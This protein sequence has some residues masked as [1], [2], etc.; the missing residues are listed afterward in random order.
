MPLPVGDDAVARDGWG[1]KATAHTPGEHHGEVYKRH[2]QCVCVYAKET[3]YRAI[4]A[5][6]NRVRKVQATETGCESATDTP[7]TCEQNRW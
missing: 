2:E 5:H 7:P 4:L 3:A 6:A 1:Q